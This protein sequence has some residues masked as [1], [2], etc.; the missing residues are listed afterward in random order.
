MCWTGRGRVKASSSVWHSVYGAIFRA[1]LKTDRN[2]PGTSLLPARSQGSDIRVCRFPHVRPFRLI[3]NSKSRPAYDRPGWHK[4]PANYR[5]LWMKWKEG[6]TEKIITF[7][8][9]R[10]RLSHSISSFVA[11][12]SLFTLFCMCDNAKANAG[13]ENKKNEVSDERKKLFSLPENE[14]ERSSA[15]WFH[16]QV[17]ISWRRTLDARG[18]LWG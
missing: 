10:G 3:C 13:N 7:R 17:C 11:T 5:S 8:A 14:K 2:W 18:S 15:F 4:K 1:D 12:L 6:K 9:S 16:S